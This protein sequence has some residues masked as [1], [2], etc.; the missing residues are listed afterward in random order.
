[1]SFARFGLPWSSSLTEI[2]KDRKSRKN[3]IR[4]IFKDFW[5]EFFFFSVKLTETVK[6][7]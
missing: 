3:H 1:M 2:K 6:L 5:G 4:C 7:I